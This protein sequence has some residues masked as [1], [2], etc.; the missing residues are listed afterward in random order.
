[1][2]ILYLADI[3]FPLERANGIQTAETCAALAA[4]GH[5][6]TLLVRPDTG[7]PPRDPWAYYDLPPVDGLGVRRAR[8]RGPQAARRLGYLASALAHAMRREAH[9]AILT[10]DL[11]VAA[12]I[13][14]LPSAWRAP[15]VY[16]SHG[17]AP[18]VGDMLPEVVSGARRAS[19]TKQRR[20]W[21]RERRVWRKADG[22][23]TITKALAAELAERFGPRDRVTV[24]PD[25]VRLPTRSPAL[26]AFGERPVVGYAGH[27]YPWKGV[28]VLLEALVDLP[29][30]SGLIVGGHPEESDLAR[31]QTLA[32]ALGLAARVTFTGWVGRSDVVA[33]LGQADVLV[34]PNPA[35]P[36]ASRYTSPLKLF[37]YM[38]ARR[39]IVASDL[40]AIREVLADRDNAV[41]VAPGDPHALA[42]GIRRVLDD[43]D[44][45][46]RLAERAYADVADY[47]WARRAARLEA[48]LAR[49]VTSA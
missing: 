2:R 21:R 6:V 32:R 43:R 41:L 5:S 14:R 46:R 12:A 30:V 38:A 7:R 11:G 15:V 10:R 48:L 9:D 37:E 22:Y 1:M 13:L 42:A 4:R 35:T 39:P 25:G 17:V 33:R 36:I 34:L 18:V 31:L 24:V 16:E 44:F 28:E 27:L 8:V 26:P 23:V 40:P 20:L 29:Q 19:A 47:T 49:V 45:A 3:R